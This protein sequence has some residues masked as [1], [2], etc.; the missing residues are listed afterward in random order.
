MGYPKIVNFLVLED[1]NGNSL[2]HLLS[3]GVVIT[4]NLAITYG[5]E[6]GDLLTFSLTSL[7]ETSKKEVTLP[8]ENV[9]DNYLS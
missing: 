3:E 9:Y 4:K 7:D 2:N 5:L 6:I 1:I 8:I